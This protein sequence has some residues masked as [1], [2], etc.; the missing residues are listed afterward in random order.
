MI[1]LAPAQ[2]GSF[3]QTRPVPRGPNSHLWQPLTK[4]SQPSDATGSGSTPKPCTPSTHNRICRPAGREAFARRTA[5][6][7]CRIGSFSPVLEC[8]HVT[9]T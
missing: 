4:K 1:S 6:A 9:A 8:T 5:A 2:A 7:I 3:A